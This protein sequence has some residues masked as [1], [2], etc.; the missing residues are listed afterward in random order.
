MI[1]ITSTGEHSINVEMIGAHG[2]GVGNMTSGLQEHQQKIMNNGTIN[3][4]Q[5]IFEA[6][7]SKINTSLTQ[8]MSAVEQSVGN[9][10][11]ALAAFGA[12]QDGYFTY[13]IIL[14]TPRMKFHYF[15]VDPGNGQILATKEVSQKELEKLHQEHSFE[16]VRSDGSGGSVSGFPFLIPH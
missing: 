11:F 1:A 3:L 13:S 9:D 15:I 16:V 7:G 6:I 4:E 5:T 14:G 12:E 8:A 10:S 2:S